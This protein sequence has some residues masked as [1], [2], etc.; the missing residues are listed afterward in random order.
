MNEKDKNELVGQ[1]NAIRQSLEPQIKKRSIGLSEK[2][3]YRL[4][5]I[6]A[7]REFRARQTSLKDTVTILWNRRYFNE[8]LAKVISRKTRSKGIKDVQESIGLGS[9][10]VRGFKR[11]N[12][13]YGHDGGDDIL[14][15][16]GTTLN[17]GGGLRSTDIAAR[18]GGDE[19]N[20]LLYDVEPHITGDYHLNPK[21]GLAIA[22]LRLV[23]S[24]HTQHIKLKDQSDGKVVDESY[25]FDLGVTLIQDTDT[26]EKAMKRADRASYE[27][28]N[29]LS[30]DAIQ[31]VIASEVDGVDIFEVASFR[32]SSPVEKTQTG[33]NH[34]VTFEPTENYPPR[35]ISER[36]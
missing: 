30:P 29:R 3:R 9:G 16:V 2:D 6:A 1:Y 28:K 22:A 19:F 14:R 18:M 5:S 25:H 7:A 34:I 24:M 4:V 36:A 32:L 23:E 21:A 15:A 8:Q 27:A 17:N 31:I 35:I 20:I 33:L 10:D 11:Y 13:T 26:Q 12:D